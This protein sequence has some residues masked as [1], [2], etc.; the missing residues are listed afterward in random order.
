MFF[1]VFFSAVVSIIVQLTTYYYDYYKCLCSCYNKNNSG[2]APT[3]TSATIVVADKIDLFLSSSDNKGWIFFE[4]GGDSNQSMSRTLVYS[5]YHSYLAGADAAAAAAA[6]AAKNFPMVMYYHQQEP[7]SLSL[8]N[9]IFPTTTY[10]L[11]RSFS[12]CLFTR[13]VYPSW[14][15]SFLLSFLFVFLFS[16][17]SSFF[18]LL[19]LFYFFS[20]RQA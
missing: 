5:V 6:P 13:S 1:F 14:I 10:K 18:L 11:I 12:H 15:L 2:L 19:C 4:G 3:R 8:S 16:F 20:F 7:P 9:L 17:F